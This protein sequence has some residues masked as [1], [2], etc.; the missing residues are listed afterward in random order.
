MDT[1]IDHWGIRKAAWQ[2]EDVLH[3]VNIE[4]YPDKPEA[5]EAQFQFVW[6]EVSYKRAL[7]ALVLLT[8]LET[9]TWYGN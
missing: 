8:V 1:D 9:P 6:A 5:R 7:L 3:D 4:V 2:L